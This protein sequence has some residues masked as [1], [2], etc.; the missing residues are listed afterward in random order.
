MDNVKFLIEQS[1]QN[2]VCFIVEDEGVDY[3]KAIDMF[4]SSQVFA[5][6]CNPATGLY[7]DSPA[8]VYELYKNEKKNGKLVQEEQ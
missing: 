2:I 6:L 7:F 3:D 1:I 8:Y 4:Y 5:K